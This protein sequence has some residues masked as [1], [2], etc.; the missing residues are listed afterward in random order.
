MVRRFVGQATKGKNVKTWKWDYSTPISIFCSSYIILIISNIFATYGCWHPCFTER[1]SHI[2]LINLTV[3]DTFQSNLMLFTIFFVQKINY[4]WSRIF[5]FFYMF[6]Q[7]NRNLEMI[8]QI[9]IY[10]DYSKA[11]MIRRTDFLVLIIE[12]IC[13]LIKLYLVLYESSYKIWNCKD[14]SNN[15]S[16][17]LR[18]VQTDLIIEKL[19]F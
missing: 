9:C 2:F 3:K 7:N 17:P 6:I 11:Q 10:Y 4:N 18:N 5:L 14:Y 15:K 13:F 16:Y 12:L 1:L 8:K 19:H